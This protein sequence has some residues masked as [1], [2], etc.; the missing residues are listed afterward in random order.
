MANNPPKKSARG[1]RTAPAKPAR[2]S[3]GNPQIAKGDG[4]VPVQAYIA[5]IPGWKRNIGE[6]LDESQMARWVKQ[7][8]A[9]PGGGKS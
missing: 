8:A 1:A 5:A 3:G 7:A 4:D 6:R 9:R 2:L